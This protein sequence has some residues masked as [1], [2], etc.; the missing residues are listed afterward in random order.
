MRLILEYIKDS[1]RRAGLR[2][3]LYYRTNLGWVDVLCLGREK[4][5]C[6]ISMHPNVE[7]YR[8]LGKCVIVTNFNSVD[9]EAVFTTLNNV[10]KIFSTMFPKDFMPYEDWLDSY[11][12]RDGEFYERACEF[13]RDRYGKTIGRKLVDA[14]AF[15]YTAGQAL[16]STEQRVPYS[17]LFP[18]L[19]E[20]GLIVRETK[21]IAKPKN[22]T[23]S[24]TI[25]G[26]RIAKCSIYNR[27][28]EDRIYRIAKKFGF[29]KLFLAVIGLSDRRGMFFREIDFESSSNFYDLISRID[30][31]SLLKL[32]MGKT[33]LEGLCSA[34]CYTVFY[35]DVIDLFEELMRMGLA[36]NYP[37]HDAYGTFLGRVYGTPKEVASV[38]S[39]M[40]FCE[41]DCKYVERFKDL[42]DM[43]QKRLGRGVEFER[44][45]ELG[46]VEMKG[47]GI[48]LSDKFENFV[49]VRLA[50]LLSEVCD[51]IH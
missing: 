29:E 35:N 38:L 32:A 1:V 36:F 30:I 26:M 34:L 18:Y 6:D 28:D 13:M 15:L 50:K 27:I 40:S 5:I 51:E 42:V 33:P 9:G 11:V 43:F 8:K 46:V 20:M 37:V 22:F 24:L 23:A 47:G 49:K 21:E 41:I 48:K 16:D 17:A 44:A 14:I 25:D 7:R 2:P 45:L 19:N 39:S 12:D 10:H 3:K 31:H 4:L